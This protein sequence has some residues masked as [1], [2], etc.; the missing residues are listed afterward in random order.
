M[1]SRSFKATIDPREKLV[2]A[3]AKPGATALRCV[4]SHDPRSREPRVVA[5][6]LPVSAYALWRL[7]RDR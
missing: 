1:F 2:L 6:N 5:T 7:Y 4:V 3:D